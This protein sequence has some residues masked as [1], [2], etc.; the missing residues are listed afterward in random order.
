MSY[1]QVL[2]RQAQQRREYESK[3]MYD[4]SRER[5]DY[6][7]K[8]RK[9]ALD[10]LLEFINGDI[11]CLMDYSKSVS[12]EKQQ[13]AREYDGLLAELR[14]YAELLGRDFEEADSEYRR[15]RD[16]YDSLDD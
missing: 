8:E 7:P 3:A 12:P 9:Y 11:E 16:Y 14:K 15:D 13:V 1:V 6:N 5:P 4:E 10:N 2:E